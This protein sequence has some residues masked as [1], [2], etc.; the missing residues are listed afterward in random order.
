MKA[1]KKLLVSLAIVLALLLLTTYLIWENRFRIRI[2]LAGSSIEAIELS[3]SDTPI[4]TLSLGELLSSDEVILDQS[5]MLVNTEHLLPEDFVPDL[6]E[7]KTS[8]V[9]MN[10]CILDSYAALSGAIREICGDKLYVSSSVRS[11]AE[12]EELYKEDPTTA[13][14]PGASEHHTG[15]CLD[16]YVA[17]HAGMAFLDADAGKYVADHCSEYGFII[18]YPDYGTEITGIRYEPWH[19][20]FVGQPHAAVI[21]S[22]RLTLEEYIE[23]LTPNAVYKAGDALILRSFPDEEG[24]IAIPDVDGTIHL[25]PDNTGAYIVTVTL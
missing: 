23:G 6:A 5:L 18:R 1:R 9:M 20:R 24:K 8:T 16:V 3:E 7:Y 2:W 12:Q 21:A 4:R 14:L 19:I 22:N 17:Y 13:T 25:S 11:F 15:L 10:T